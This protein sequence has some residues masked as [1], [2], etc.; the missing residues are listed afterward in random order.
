M[1]LKRNFYAKQSAK[2][3][4]LQHLQTKNL[5]INIVLNNFVQPYNKLVNAWKTRPKPNGAKN[6]YVSETT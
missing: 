6:I 4:L 1:L 3:R 2:K 5:H